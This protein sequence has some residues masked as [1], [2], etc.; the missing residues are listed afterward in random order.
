MRIVINHIVKE[1][2]IL[3]VV[4]ILIV[5]DGALAHLEK[6]HML[7]VVIVLLI[8]PVRL[9]L[10]VI[11]HLRFLMCLSGLMVQVE[12]IRK[13]QIICSVRVQLVE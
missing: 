3:R 12:L 1:K 5:K 2:I 4:L 13:Q 7:K 8:Q 11:H 10:V 9:F 6:I